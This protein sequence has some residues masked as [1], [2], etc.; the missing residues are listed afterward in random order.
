[1]GRSFHR[2]D[3]LAARLAAECF[4]AAP[5]TQDKGQ[6]KGPV[7]PL[8]NARKERTSDKGPGFLSNDRKERAKDKR[9]E[10]RGKRQEEALK[11]TT[12]D[13]PETRLLLAEYEAGELEPAWVELGAMPADVSTKA[14]LGVVPKHVR[15]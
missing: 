7:G 15:Q 3:E 12:G 11:D 2:D 4:G 8:S 9:K 1:M 14:R 10:E 6:D 13:E 5:G